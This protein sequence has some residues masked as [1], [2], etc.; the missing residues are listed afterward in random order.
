MYNVHH[1]GAIHNSNTSQKRTQL[2]RLFSSYSPMAWPGVITKLNTHTLGPAR[3][4]FGELMSTTG[5]AYI[6][7]NVLS[8]I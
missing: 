3:K 4:G 7:R 8:L 6:Q 1:L 2:V 5:Y